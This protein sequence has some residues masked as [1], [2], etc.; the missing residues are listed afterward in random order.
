[1]EDEQEVEESDVMEH[2]PVS[3]VKEDRIIIAIDF[4][5]TFSSVAYTVLPKGLSPEKVNVSRVKC[6]GNYPGYEPPPG[7]P[8]VRQDV[9]TE[10]W[11][12]DRRD[13]FINGAD[14]DQHPDSENEE[15]SS[16]DDYV[17]EGE[18]SQFEDDGGSEA[19]AATQHRSTRTIPTTQYWGFG[20]QQR[21]SMTDIPRNEA[22][23][24]ARFK[25]NLDRKEET[26][27]IRADLRTILKALCR[28]KII[29]RDTDIYAHYL[30]HLLRHTKEQLLFSNEIHRDM[31]TQFVLCVPAKWPMNACRIMQTALEEAVKESGLGEQANCSVH[32]MFM[33]S[34]P[35][36]A[37]ECILAETRSELYCDET[38]VIVDAGGGTVDAVTY[39]C[40]IDE[41]LRLS[42]EVAADSQLCGASFINEK[43]EKKL[44]QKLSSETYLVKNGK[45][46]KT[47]V[48]AK[49][50]VFENNQKRR[51]DTSNPRTQRVTI[52]IDDL[53]ENSKKHFYQNL[54]ELKHKTVREL[55]EDSLQGVER[56]LQS[57]LELAESQGHRVQK[58]ILTG[59]FGQSPSLQSHLRTYLKKRRNIN[60]WEMD[61]IVPRNPSTAVARGAVLRA[62]NKRLGPDR[63]TQCSYG[64]LVS[65][66]YEPE[67]YEEHRRTRCRINKADGEKY[68][69]ETIHWVIQAGDRVGNMQEFP[70][71]IKHT[72]PITR[73]R[74]LC[75]EQ[76]WM[77]DHRHPLHYR[78]SHSLNKGAELVGSIV[79]DLT[80]LKDE[81]LIEPQLPSVYS[82]HSGLQKQHW[83][84]HYEVAMIVEGRSIRFEALWPLKNNLKPGQNQRVLAMKLVGIAAAFQPGTA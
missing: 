53:R 35:E 36:A 81:G 25:L 75:V 60:G 39:K 27:D 20:V 26:Q 30:T 34:E 24:L 3:N 1:M 43:F 19:N 68:V 46:L 55:F 52:Y 78:R 61:L 5:T 4:G 37:A 50:T 12:D 29:K 38:M 47:I 77:S 51:V 49:T 2:D 83:E 72:F 59:G 40:E 15:S 69:D 54:L 70:F 22:R 71:E 66:P 23:P 84:A 64:F 48:Q 13:R 80:F 10:L 8:D 16:S 17:S 73:K 28:K 9:P 63:I 76:L 33:I 11:Y 21:L 6:I 44:L 14:D 42:A 58:V 32:S 56:V 62:L 7:I 79:A 82:T 67:V 74:L 57:Q 18:Q 31:L 41:P 65:E 45:T